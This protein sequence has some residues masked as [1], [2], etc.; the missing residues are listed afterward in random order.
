[1]Q[2][3]NKPSVTP[4]LYAPTLKDPMSAAALEDT[5]ETE[6]LVKVGAIE[7]LNL[8]CFFYILLWP[9]GLR[10]GRGRCCFEFHHG[11]VLENGFYRYS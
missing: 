3:E 11:T 9:F 10:L 5:K 8:N 6:K 2:A 1:M 7:F 4:M